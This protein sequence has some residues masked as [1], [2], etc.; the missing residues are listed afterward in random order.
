MQHQLD[1]NEARAA[2]FHRD[3]ATLLCYGALAGYAFWLYAFGPALALLRAELHFSYAVIG[4]YS[5]VWAGGAAI[6]GVTF[7]ALARR[8]DRAPLLWWSAAGA[9]DPRDRRHRRAV[10]GVS[11][12]DGGRVL[13]GVA[14]GHALARAR[15]VFVC[16]AGVGNL[17][18]LSVA[19]TLAAAPGNTDA[20]NART[21]LVGGLLV[22]G[23]PYLLGSLADHLGLHAAFAVEPALAGACGLL[24]LAGLRLGRTAQPGDQAAA[25]S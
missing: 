15:R 18:P 3:P 17:Y 13:A 2:S 23:A 19:L 8:L 12:R 4:V 11:G 24:L 22:V 10:V 25:P 9:A 20:A 21:R 16:G 14:G 5:A 6:S 1:A 7:A